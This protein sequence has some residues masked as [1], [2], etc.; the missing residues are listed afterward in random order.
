M[1]L[2]VI[3]G[4]WNV[5][6]EELE[7]S[8]WLRLVNA[9][10]VRPAGGAATCHDKCYDYFVV[11]NNYLH[12]IIGA[13]AIM[14]AGWTPHSPCRLFV[15]GRPTVL[16]VR[17]IKSPF[18]LPAVLPHGP[19]TLA[20]T[21]RE[22]VIDPGCLDT[23]GMRVMQAVE[24]CLYRLAG[25]ERGVS[26]ASRADGPELVM[27]PLPRQATASLGRGGPLV[28]AWAILICW[29][30]TFLTSTVHARRQAALWRLLYSDVGLWGIRD[31]RL[32]EGVRICH[33]WRDRLSRE[34]LLVSHWAKAV[35]KEACL[36]VQ[37]EA[38]AAADAR[39]K[40][41]NKWLKDG[42]GRGL[43]RQHQM[44]RV[45]SGWVAAKA[46]AVDIFEDQEPDGT[47]GL[48]VEELEMMRE[49]HV[50]EDALG[51]KGS[52]TRRK[53][54]R[55]GNSGGSSRGAMGRGRQGPG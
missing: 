52:S 48:T 15:T 41:F 40:D 13:R 51:I 11:S 32:A 43:K 21:E 50:F 46:E 19:M 38:R 22:V 17:A 20:D 53:G 5:T 54:W 18:S 4:D 30:R 23:T 35:Y 27:R 49:I 7:T 10:V 42:P 28:R 44:S 26:E 29:L 39:A 47:D 2:W 37:V 3:G 34:W 12:N 14:D 24:Q 8:G 36:R 31:E 6:P 25:H 1:A 16:K 45:A 33:A 9:S 55:Q